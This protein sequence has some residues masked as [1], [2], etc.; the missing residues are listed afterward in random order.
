MKELT[1]LEYAAEKG[2]SDMVA[3]LMKKYH[4]SKKVHGSEEYMANVCSCNSATVQP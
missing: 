1:A 4:S 2:W 3:L